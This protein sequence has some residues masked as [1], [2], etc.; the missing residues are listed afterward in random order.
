MHEPDLVEGGGEPR[1]RCR[2]TSATHPGCRGAA[3]PSRPSWETACP[4]VRTDGRGCRVLISGTGC[5]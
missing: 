2:A 3:G 1:L 4:P 5:Q